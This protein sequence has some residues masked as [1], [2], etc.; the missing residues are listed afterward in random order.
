MLPEVAQRGV[1]SEVLLNVECNVN[2]HVNLHTEMVNGLVEK[3]HQID[4]ALD[5]LIDDVP[6]NSIQLSSSAIA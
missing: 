4:S 3:C 6:P 1:F 2:S 5:P